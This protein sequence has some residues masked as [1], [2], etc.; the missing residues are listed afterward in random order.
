MER[1]AARLVVRNGTFFDAPAA[2]MSEQR[3]AVVDGGRISWIGP[4]AECVSQPDD[5]VIDASGHTVLPGLIDCHVHLSLDATPQRERMYLRTRTD[6]WHYYALANAQKHLAA[7]FTCVRDCG[8]EYGLWSPAL[9]ATFDAGVLPG[10]R[11]L[12][13]TIPIAQ[14]GNQE[15]IHPRALVDDTRR[16]NEVLTGVDGVR[17]AVRERAFLG[18]DFIKTLTTGGVLHG[19]ASGVG[20]S[21][22]TPEELAAM[23][24]EAHRIGKRV[25]CHAHGVA[26]I[27]AAVEAGIDTIE[28]GSLLDD[29]TAD[30]MVE[31]GTWLVPTQSAGIGLSEPEVTAQLPPE[32]VAKTRA[33]MERL[34]DNHKS[35]FERGVRFALGTDAGTP[36]NPHG[37]TAKE[38]E[39]MVANV[40][41]SPAEALQTA[42]IRSAEAIGMEGLIGSLEPGKAADMVICTTN[43]VDDIASLQDQTNIAW[44]I[45]NGKVVARHGVIEFDPRIGE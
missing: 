44:V 35:A 23:A 27:R 11:L 7:G 5:I 10:P 14:W 32:V 17:H 37:R 1:H 22:F 4:D 43:P 34:I 29:E 19:M 41:M 28:H 39:R 13:A 3:T 2:T 45:K 30:L 31:R 20:T 16:H 24:E 25:A 36:G 40:G 9:R 8:D 33:V 26:G 15:A 21:L 38:I 18:A 6:Q 42:T 12:V